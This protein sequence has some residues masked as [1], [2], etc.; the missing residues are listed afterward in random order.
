MKLIDII[1]LSL[2]GIGLIYFY[3][4][5]RKYTSISAYHEKLERLNKLKLLIITIENNKKE[6]DELIKSINADT[7]YDE[8]LIDKLIKYRNN[9]E[10]LNVLE[11]ELIETEKYIRTANMY[12]N[13][14]KNMFGT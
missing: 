14:F 11:K 8:E 13:A 1:L 7:H 4:D 3:F 2:C 9:E 5:R 6:T 10:K 12:K